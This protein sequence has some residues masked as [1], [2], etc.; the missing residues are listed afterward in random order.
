VVLVE[1]ALLAPAVVVSHSRALTTAALIGDRCN[2]HPG[3]GSMSYDASIRT[4]VRSYLS[5]LAET[6]AAIGDDADVLATGV[7]KSMN[8]LELIKSPRG[9][10]WCHSHSARA[11]CRPQFEF[12]PSG[13]TS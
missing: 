3:G 6:G 8:L 7:I 9:A 4:E 5:T 11:V 13:A 1:L 12:P 2:P 10:L